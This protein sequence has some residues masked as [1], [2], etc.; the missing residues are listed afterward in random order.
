MRIRSAGELLYG[1]LR[2]ALRELVRRVRDD[3]EL[4][5]S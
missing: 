3:L 5:E 1:Q 4:R 2:L